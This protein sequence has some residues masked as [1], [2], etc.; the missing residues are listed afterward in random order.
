[1]NYTSRFHLCCV[2]ASV[3]QEDGLRQ[4]AKIKAPSVS[5]A[6]TSHFTGARSL[7]KELLTSNACNVFCWGAGR[8]TEGPSFTKNGIHATM[9]EILS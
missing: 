5:E 2:T 7:T 9:D 6:M 1:M 8:N 4:P 3:I